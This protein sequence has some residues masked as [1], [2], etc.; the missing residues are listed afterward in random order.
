LKKP[1][2]LTA[3]RKLTSV[4]TLAADFSE[5]ISLET[6]CFNIRGVTNPQDKTPLERVAQP[7]PNSNTARVE[8]SSSKYHKAV[9]CKQEN[10]LSVYRLYMNKHARL[11]QK[12]SD[13]TKATFFSQTS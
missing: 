1:L 12:R 11:K 6:K 3:L 2:L 10:K 7:R 13:E 4:K 8:S 9:N 5:S